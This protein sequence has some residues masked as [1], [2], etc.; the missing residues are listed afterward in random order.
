MKHCPWI[1]L[2]TCHL[3]AAAGLGEAESTALR[4]WFATPPDQRP[5]LPDAIANLKASSPEDAKTLRD[6]VWNAYREGAQQLGWNR[7][8]AEIPPTLEEIAAL[9]ADQRPKLEPAQISAGGKTMPYFLVA[10][11]TKPASGWPLV[12]SLHGGGGNPQAQG[13]HAWDV[14]TR[15]WQAQMALFERLYPANALYFIPRMADDREGRWWYDYCQEIYDQIIRRA[16]LFREVDP[17]R[18]LI[19]GISEGGYAAFRLPANQPDRWAAA[20]AMAA[21]EPLATSPPENLRHTAFR[22]DIGAEDTMFDRIGLARTYMQK[23]DE[24]AQS[25]PREYTHHFGEQ[26]GRGHGIDYQACPEWIINPSRN[27]RPKALT[28]T[29]QKLHNTLHTHNYWL[30]LATPPADLPVQLTA[31][32]DAN[33]ITLTATHKGQPT[34]DLKLR[35]VLDDALVDLNQPVTV[36]LNGTTA[37]QGLLPRSAATLVRTLTGRGDPAMMFSAELTLPATAP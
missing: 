28:W 18:I 24:L 8:I 1:L 17:N 16:V 7:E 33:T 19:M 32:I 36:K 12:I 11:G 6:A 21:A 3:A 2:A 9:P 13:P 23:L 20:G 37:H 10:K 34:H 27:P 30:E 31:A 14:N 35:L 22:C 25:H 26:K 4:T 29:V 15:E 5:T